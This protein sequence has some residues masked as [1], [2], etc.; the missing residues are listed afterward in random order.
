MK[1]LVCRLLLLLAL[2]VVSARAMSATGDGWWLLLPRLEAGR[3]VYYRVAVEGT[4]VAPPHGDARRRVPAM[5]QRDFP[6][7]ESGCGPTAA[8]NWLLWMENEGLFGR[9]PSRT[10]TPER[11]RSLF[12]RIDREILTLSANGSRGA[13]GGSSMA[14]LAVTMDRLVDERSEGA[15]RLHFAHFEPPLRVVDLLEFTRGMRSGILLTRVVNDRQ[16]LVAGEY[17][18]VSLVAG[19]RAGGLMVN[20]WGARVYGHLRTLPEGQFFFPQD[21]S[22]EALRIEGALCFVPLRLAGPAP[23]LPPPGE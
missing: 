22:Q 12:H 1:R 14:E 5:N 23:K 4:E 15:L 6:A 17:H 8:L 20:N 21:S 10:I 18:A 11:A 2:A 13:R 16:T 9:R 3:M 19:D 7:P